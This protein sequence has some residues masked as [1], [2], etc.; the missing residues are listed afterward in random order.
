MNVRKLFGLGAVAAIALLSATPASAAYLFDVDQAGTDVVVTGSGSL[1]TTGLTSAF[2]TSI[3]GAVHASWGLMV[4]GEGLG[5][6]YA[7]LSGPASFGGDVNARADKM[8]GTAVGINMFS[9]N[10]FFVDRSYV[11]G[12]ELGISTAVFSNTTIAKL[13]L[14]VGTYAYA[15]NRGAN[16]DSIT[17]R[18]NAA[19]AAVPEPATWAMM[20]LGFGVIGYALRRRTVLR[21]V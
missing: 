13:G 4:V 15:F 1:N 21:F 17:V 7:A 10:Y 6:V 19:T 5:P 8:T 18:I 20:M 14:K 12:A 11:S 9:G 3:N 16:A 2:N